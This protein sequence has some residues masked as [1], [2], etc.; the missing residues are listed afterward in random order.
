MRQLDGSSPI[1][2]LTRDKV[3]VQA[4]RDP[5]LALSGGPGLAAGGGPGAGVAAEARRIAS[6]CG[7]IE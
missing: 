5:G 7:D 6:A 2:I 4:A 3:T 1:R